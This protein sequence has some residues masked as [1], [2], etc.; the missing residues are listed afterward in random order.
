MLSTSRAQ[1]LSLLAQMAEHVEAM[2][3]RIKDLREARGLTQSQLARL[4][5]GTVDASQISR[6]ERGKH[7][8]TVD[9]REA[10]AEALGTTVAALMVDEPDKTVT[11]DLANGFDEDAD[12]RKL[13]L[14]MRS[15][16]R[17]LA[18][19]VRRLSDQAGG[20]QSGTS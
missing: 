9:H 13:V 16:L 4:M 2:G 17:E 14:A 3:R 11:P 12:L 15:D 6:W 8:P 20:T 5:P 1:R 18:L 7:E 19:E 10:L